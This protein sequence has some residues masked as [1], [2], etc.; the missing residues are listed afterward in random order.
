MAPDG[1]DKRPRTPTPTRARSID[2]VAHSLFSRV[3]D[4]QAWLA[5]IVE[6]S[7]DAIVGK[8]LDSIIHS[9]NA[10]ATRLF[11]YEPDEIIGRSVL[12]LFPPE[13]VHEEA[14][15]I[16][17]LSRGERVEHY[18][19]TRVRKDGSR[20]EVSLSVSPIRDEQGTIIGAAKIAR[21]I[22]QQRRYEARL[23]E[24]AALIDLAQDAM[25][26]RDAE[27]RIVFW[28]AAAERAYGWSLAEVA[29][30]CVHELLQTRFPDDLE[31]IRRTLRDT[32]QWLGDL[33]QTRRNGETLIMSSRWAARVDDAGR[34]VG[35]LATNRDVTDARRLEEAERA[36][37]EQLQDQAMELEQQ[38]MELEQQVEEAQ[39]LTEELEA[40][41]RQLEE[42]ARQ[43]QQARDHAETANRSKSDFLAVMSH[44]LRTP[45][46]AIVG[47]V[48]LMEAGVRGPLTDDQTKD[49]ARIRR[50]ARTLLQLI[51]D[52]LSFAKLE[53]GRIEY[54]IS[55][56]PV[57]EMLE[58]FTLLIAPQIQAKDVEF[59]TM[60]TDPS[61][62]ARADREKAERI[63]LNL[64][65]NAIKFTDRGRVELRCETDDSHVHITVRDTGRGI[66]SDQLE[67]IFEPFVQ[68][69]RGLKRTA[70]GTGLGL[71]IARDLAQGMGG[72]LVAEST[73]GVG[74]AFTL[75]LPRA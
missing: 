34:V 17:R 36:L 60:C 41:N 26:V 59:S 25:I 52:V 68:V 28:N 10:A 33:A 47:Y 44:E 23:R 40:T 55:D 51:E 12:K 4:P 29:G 72:T 73:P 48:D 14:E 6:S 45:L 64:L 49:L 27:D 74:S 24:Q 54:H 15:I 53:S 19:T 21:D 32:G 65:S 39:A 50:S 57:G 62:T 46:N 31:Q 35:V 9:W 67:K 42:T 5:A 18:E 20:I 43:A 66:P 61:V 7:D 71:S 75:S 16:G 37:T 69:E 8:T 38:A 63:V 30:R 56:I 3:R 13:L 58:D 1:S 2:P 11:G 70:T 22:T